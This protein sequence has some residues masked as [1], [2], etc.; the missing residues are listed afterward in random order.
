MFQQSGVNTDNFGTHSV[1][2]VTA[3]KRMG[4]IVQEIM[5]TA[6][7]SKESTFAKY[8]DKDIQ[9]AGFDMAVLKSTCKN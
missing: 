2:S 4:A 6:G 1:C 3:A 7:W 8:Y 9:S 5:S